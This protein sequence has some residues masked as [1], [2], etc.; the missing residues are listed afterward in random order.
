[1]S[2]DEAYRSDKQNNNDNNDNNNNNMLS[3][4]TEVS[5]MLEK[6]IAGVLAMG[7]EE[8]WLSGP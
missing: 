6:L 1:M 5:S 2:L 7:S 4:M 8:V 3:L